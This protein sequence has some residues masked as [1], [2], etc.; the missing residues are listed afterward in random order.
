MKVCFIKFIVFGIT[1]VFPQALPDYPPL[2]NLQNYDDSYDP[3][4]YIYNFPTR[5]VQLYVK[6]FHTF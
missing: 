6:N 1:L 2:I 3:H 4:S 5:F